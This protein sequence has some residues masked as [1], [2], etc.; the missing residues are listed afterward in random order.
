M[1]NK[2]H[3]Q[4]QTNKLKSEFTPACSP[5]P[6]GIKYFYLLFCITMERLE[7]AKK[8]H[9]ELSEKIVRLKIFLS[10][11]KDE[12]DKE[13]YALL[14]AQNYAMDLY[15]DILAKRIEKHS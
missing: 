13:D 4:G 11:Q 3:S 1:R 2:Q 8:E 14:L 10:S 7:R 5:V 15:L 9:E 6:V 12:L